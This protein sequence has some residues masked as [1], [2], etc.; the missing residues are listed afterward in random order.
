MSARSRLHLLLAAAALALAV[1]RPAAAAVRPANERIEL[2]PLT[3]EVT[4]LQPTQLFATRSWEIP[5]YEPE[6]AP[7][8]R[9]PIELLMP[10]VGPESLDLKI[11]FERFEFLAGA[12]M[13]MTTRYPIV[14]RIDCA[15]G[16]CYWWIR[17][18]VDATDEWTVFLE[19]F[20]SSS[21]ILGSSTIYPSYIWDG[22]QVQLGLKYH[23]ND[24]ASLETGPV[25]YCMSATR[26]ESN[27]GARLEIMLEF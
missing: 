21:A 10:E 9:G 14:P 7:E 5:T 23:F 18:S 12:D 26:R 20:Q 17:A 22:V 3:P 2:H 11:R 1:T 16:E 4:S 8:A 27:V 25:L 24:R 13:N 15:T 19:S 6:Y